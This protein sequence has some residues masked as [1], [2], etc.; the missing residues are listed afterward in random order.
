MG[1]QRFDEDKY[2]ELYTSDKYITKWDKI[3]NEPS[4]VFAN[5]SDEWFDQ[6]GEPVEDLGDEYP[7]GV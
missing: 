5:K 2:D 1:R 6:Q 7:R 4:D 3:V